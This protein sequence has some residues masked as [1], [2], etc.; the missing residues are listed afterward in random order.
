MNKL[1]VEKYGYISKK[2]KNLDTIIVW[3][4]LFLI[5]FGAF[6]LLIYFILSISSSSTSPTIYIS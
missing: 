1:L 6:I 2:A 4:A 5:K 3:N